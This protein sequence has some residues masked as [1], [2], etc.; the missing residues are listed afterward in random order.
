MEIV[1]LMSIPVLYLNQTFYARPGQ[2]KA[3]L[4]AQIEA[5]STKMDC[6]LL[7]AL[8]VTVSIRLLE[9]VLPASL[10][11][12]SFKEN[13]FTH[14][15]ILPHQV[16]LDA[17]LGTGTTKYVLLALKT[18]LSMLKK[19]VSLSLIN[20]ELM[21]LT[22]TV[23]NVTKVMILKKVN[24]FSLFPTMPNL[25]I[26]DVELGIGIIKF[27]LL[28]LKDG[29]SMLTQ[30]VLQFLTNVKLMPKMETVPLVI[31]DMILNKDNVC[32]LNSIMLDLLIWDVLPGIGTIKFV[33][34]V[35]KIGSSTQTKSVFQYLINA[36]LMPIME[37]VPHVI[38]DM[39]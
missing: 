28:A 27:V 22:D 25:P 21:M 3:V 26:K 4:L 17:E 2:K 13:V 8:N 32:S 34:L 9:T 5:S 39:I 37:T 16:T 6:V 35:Q 36:K 10:D 29:S 18:G 11:M 20:V 23:L 33:F 24:V 12:I 15:P 1:L 31:K 19:S 38:K 30:S 7:L 14:P